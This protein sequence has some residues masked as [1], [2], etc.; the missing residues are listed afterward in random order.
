[1]VTD[2]TGRYSEIFINIDDKVMHALLSSS[3][4][5]STSTGARETTSSSEDERGFIGI[6]YV[7]FEK[8]SSLYECFFFQNI[9]SQLYKTVC[10]IEYNYKS[11]HLPDSSTESG[12]III[13]RLDDK[14]SDSG[15]G[16][17]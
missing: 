5:S 7:H 8:V 17:E 1:M 2:R 15:G 14:N 9:I 11:S 10:I 16:G 12:I 3:S 6:F 4:S 13:I